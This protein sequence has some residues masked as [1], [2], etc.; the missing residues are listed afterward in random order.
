ME[1]LDVCFAVVVRVDLSDGLE[2]L[3]EF[4]VVGVFPIGCGTFLGFRALCGW[5]VV[6]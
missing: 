6:G 2:E 1:F 5:H 4:V 3:G